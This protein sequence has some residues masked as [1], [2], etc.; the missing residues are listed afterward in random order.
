MSQSL[1]GLLLPFP[2]LLAQL[3]AVFVSFAVS[4]SRR[5]TIPPSTSRN[6][7]LS[8]FYQGL[9]GLECRQRTQYDGCKLPGFTIASRMSAPRNGCL[10]LK[11]SEAH[12]QSLMLLESYSFFAANTQ[13]ARR[14]INRIQ[15][16]E[17]RSEFCPPF[18]LTKVYYQPICRFGGIHSKGLGE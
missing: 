14:A 7:D 17:W 1:L 12:T 18:S 2:S 8:Q 4:P 16:A 11:R 9:W 6:A 3:V 13:L 10:Y 15:Q 5:V